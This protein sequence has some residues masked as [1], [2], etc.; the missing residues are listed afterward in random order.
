MISPFLTCEEAYLLAKFLHGL[1]SQVRL[2][3]GPVPVVG[4]DDTYP[5]DRRGR[6]IQPVRFTIR[7]EK[8][9]N[10]R[11]VEAILRHFQGEVL[12]FDELLRMAQEGKFK[13]IYLAAGYPPRLGGWITEEQA[14]SLKQIPLLIVQDLFPSA[15]SAIAKYVIPAATFAEKDGTFVNHAGLAQCIRWGIR[16]PDGVWA[17][18][19]VFLDLME[20]RGLVHAPSLRAELAREVPYFAPLA[21]EPGDLGVLL[22]STGGMLSRP[23]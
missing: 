21:Q 2:F 3:L 7:A 13:A 16:P 18:G 11:G 14:A 15:V 17:D 10:R 5:K 19:H 12:G 23:T 20:R 8:C 4:E 1:S 6:P 9:P 22:D